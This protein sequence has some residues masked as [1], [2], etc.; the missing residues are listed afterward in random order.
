MNLKLSEYIDCHGKFNYFSIL[1]EAISI[2]YFSNC[3]LFSYIVLYL[4]YYFVLFNKTIKSYNNILDTLYVLL[5]TN[6]ILA[7][8]LFI[9]HWKKVASKFIKL[10]CFP[11]KQ[12][13]LDNTIF[14]KLHEKYRNEMIYVRICVIF[15]HW[16]PILFISPMVT[17]VAPLIIS[18]LVILSVYMSIIKNPYGNLPVIQYVTIY[19]VTLFIVGYLIGKK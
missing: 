3:I 13:K 18:T 8:Y 16:L 17:P 11:E 2:K 15:I 1:F 9:R 7:T 14:I 10:H 4:L 5:I 12:S 6:A 19:L